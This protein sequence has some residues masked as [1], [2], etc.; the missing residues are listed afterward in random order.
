MKR[1]PI[2]PS[3]RTAPEDR[4]PGGRASPD[5]FREALSRW[6]AGV[7]VIA[8]REP[9]RVYA[10]TVSS[11]TSV[12]ADPPLVLI[13]LGAG[14]QVLPFLSEGRRFTV[15]ILSVGQRR[16]AT[17][18]ADS[19]PVGPSPFPSQGDPFLEGSLAALACSVR[20]VVEAAMSRVVIASVEEARPGGEGE[21]L[22]H[23]GR[24]YRMLG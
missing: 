22:V 13:S 24:E 16:L 18:F 5:D 2:R 23:Y 7:A 6:V 17:V 12:S 19:F 1:R 3:V 9:D 4:E 20:T 8:V 15:S 14:A 11:F 21:P 10:T